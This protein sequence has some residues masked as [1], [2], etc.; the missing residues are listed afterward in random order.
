MALVACTVFEI[1]LLNLDRSY[2]AKFQVLAQNEVYLEIHLGDCRTY[3]PHRVSV[4]YIF[5]RVIFVK[6]RLGN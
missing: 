2:S 4:R 5:Y 6:P 1:E 3:N